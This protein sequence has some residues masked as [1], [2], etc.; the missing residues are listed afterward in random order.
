[1]NSRALY[2]IAIA[3]LAIAVVA[4]VTSRKA[5]APPQ[6][7]A[8]TTEAKLCPD[9]SSVGRTGPNCEFAACPGQGNVGSVPAGWQTTSTASGA[10]FSYP[11]DLGTT[12]IHAQDWPPKLQIVAGPYSCNAAGS[13][14]AQAGRT[15]PVT[16]SGHTYCRT[17]ESEG[18]AGSIYTQYA[19]A[20][21]ITS[22]SQAGKVTILTFT[23][24]MTQCGNYPEPQMTA[25]NQ[26]RASFNID[27]TVDQIAQTLRVQ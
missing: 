26:E 14:T 20:M 11:A 4:F 18:A 23:L 19:Y 10:T 7:T 6:Q 13:E 21:P 3:A 15:A 25:C 17:V 1:M 27:S 8:C 9:G 5:V 12:Y 16:I 24:R 22:G 2:A